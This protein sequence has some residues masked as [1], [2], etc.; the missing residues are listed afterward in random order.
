MVANPMSSCFACHSWSDDSLI[1][2]ISRSESTNDSKKVSFQF[3]DIREYECTLCDNPACS[4]GPPISLDW[5]YNDE[6]RQDFRSYEAKRY[7]KRIRKKNELRLPSWVREKMLKELGFSSD[8][9]YYATLRTIRVKNQ[10]L[11]SHHNFESSEAEELLR[12]FWDTLEMGSFCE[13]FQ[14]IILVYIF[15]SIF[16][17]AEI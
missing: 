15:N 7:I 1:L 17:C 12:N 11:E 8:Q 6:Y 10:R 16:N 13:Q 2:P 9:I 14:P 5:K 3:V 4:A